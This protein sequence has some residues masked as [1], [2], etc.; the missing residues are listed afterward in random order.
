MFLLVSILGTTLFSKLPA[1]LF[2]SPLF[3]EILGLIRALTLRSFSLLH[4][5]LVF[6]LLFATFKSVFL[7]Q[8]AVGR[9]FFHCCCN[10]FLALSLFISG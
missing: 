8:M 2:F 4:F 1:D 3:L 7:V 10:L 5:V 6:L 9:Y